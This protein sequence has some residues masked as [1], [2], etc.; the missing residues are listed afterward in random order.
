LGGNGTVVFGNNG[1]YDYNALRLL[2]GDTTLTIGPGITVRG[3]RGAIG[4]ATDYGGS[5]ANVGV[6]NQGTIQADVSGGTITINAQ[7]FSNQGTLAATLGTVSL[8]G[9]YALASGTLEFGLSTTNSFGK[10]SFSGN[11]PLGGT[12]SAI[13]LGG[14]LPTSSNSFPVL[15]YGS[16]TGAFA[17][18]ELPLGVL[19]QTNYGPTIFSLTVTGV[20]PVLKPIVNSSA[21]FLLQFTG[22]TN[23]I[24]S[25][26]ASTNLTLPL[27]NWATLGTASLLS[28]SLYQFIDAKSTNFPARFYMLRSP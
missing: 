19:W 21:E 15:I 1:N 25:V 6:V 12:M 26:L 8:S 18:T 7:P 5:V 24:Y 20:R 10:I 9:T 27:S 22:S 17:N 14:F 28:N 23:N 13:L 4:D 3:Q 16:Y 2:Y 11:V